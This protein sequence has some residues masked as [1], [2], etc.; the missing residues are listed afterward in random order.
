MSLT[1][2]THRLSG[3]TPSTSLQRAAAE[4]AREGYQRQSGTLPVSR[5]TPPRSRAPR[6][7]SA[8]AQVEALAG[9]LAEKAEKIQSTAVAEVRHYLGEMLRE[10]AED[11]DDRIAEVQYAGEEHS[12]TDG[13]RAGLLLAARLVAD[14]D[15]DY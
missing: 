1:P 9:L 14:P 15:V 12:V 13:L 3:H 7:K 5:P 11:T 8:T 2:G 4:C 6:G 10:L